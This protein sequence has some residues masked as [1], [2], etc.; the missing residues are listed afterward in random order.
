MKIKE[1][2]IRIFA[3]I[4]TT[5][6]AIIAIIPILEVWFKYSPEVD[7][8]VGKYSIKEEKEVSLFYFV[9]K[10][11]NVKYQIPIP[12]YIVNNSNDIVRK[13]SIFAQTEMKPIGRGYMLRMIG[14]QDQNI[15]KEQNSNL[16]YSSL[17]KE[18]VVDLSH[19]YFNIVME[20]DSNVIKD[21]FSTLLTLNYDEQEYIRTK[22]N[23]IVC[24]LGDTALFKQ[25]VAENKF[26]GTNNF[27]V[28]V[29]NDYLSITP[30]S[31]P[32]TICKLKYVE[33]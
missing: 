31:V 7:V 13:V 32:V 25:K 6:C 23:V 30:D 17:M 5:V 4:I 26:I 16:F 18:E 33:K 3:T 8:C 14:M 19:C 29:V 22:L 20:N 15:G 9:E 24:Q 2:R 10:N 1:S 21:S 27:F 11:R 12:L 28:Y